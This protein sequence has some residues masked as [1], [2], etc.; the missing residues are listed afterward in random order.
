MKARYIFLSLLLLALTALAA[1]GPLYDN[2]MPPTLSLPDAYQLALIKLGSATNQ[3]HCI[4]AK[5]TGDF[6]EP[7]WSFDFYSTNKPPMLKRYVVL[8]SG[9]V[10]EDNGVRS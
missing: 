6:G 2:S 4:S 10:F 5:V 7:G 8:F 9:K 3:L 1:V